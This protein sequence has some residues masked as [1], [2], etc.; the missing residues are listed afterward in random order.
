MNAALH[1]PRP[2]L[3]IVLLAACGGAEPSRS[4]AGAA[5]GTLTIS[6]AGSRMEGPTSVSAGWT[7]L[8]HATPADAQAHSYA[9]FLLPDGVAASD[10]V[11]AFDT[12]RTTPAGATALGGPDG[13]APEVVL[14]LAEGR[15][16]VTCIL[17]HSDGRRHATGGEWHEVRV[18]PRAAG[19]RGP[20]EPASG[21]VVDMGDF[22]FTTAEKWPAGAQ[23]I[24]VRNSGKE[25][26]LL[27]LSRLH[28]GARLADAM[29]PGAPDMTGP[30]VGISRLG[31]GG[32]AYL[33]VTLAPG[34]Y[35][36]TCL[37]PDASRGRPHAALGM[38][39][40]VE[41]VAT[42]SS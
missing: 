17:R 14:Q 12:A 35:V 24:G 32:R 3:L 18:L 42:G 6:I 13:E 20:D 40:E 4:S 19:Q 16:V 36:L 22:A 30:A 31:S 41:V 8:R 37:I 25:D 23:V 26:H 10:F 34:R 21:I 9:A 1:P 27:L 38:V 7:R 39:K 15:V 28:E 29:K 2:A 5:D 33:P 11:A